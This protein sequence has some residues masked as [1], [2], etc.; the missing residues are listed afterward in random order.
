M[1]D[2]NIAALLERCAAQYAGRVAI[3]ALGRPS[4]DYEGLWSL[5]REAR[6]AFGRVGCGPGTRIAL[7][8]ENTPEL[9]TASLAIC[10]SATC[11][12]LNPRYLEGE[13]TR[14]LRHL[15]ARLLVTTPDQDRRVVQR[16]FATRFQPVLQWNPD[17]LLSFLV[18]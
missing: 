1:L 2:A 11:V 16:S 6:D 9:A 17:F 12:P 7:V 14:L 13:L 4:L 15:G 5:M 18:R 3:E 8:A 10:A